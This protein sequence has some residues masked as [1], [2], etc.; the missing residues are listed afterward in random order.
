MKIVMWNLMTG[1]FDGGTSGEKFI[2]QT[3]KNIHPGSIVVLHDNEK[4]WPKLK[5]GLE[6][7]LKKFKS[8]AYKMAAIPE[9]I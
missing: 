6:D 2:R 8:L 1:D 9:N 5:D 7:L 3:E 4:A